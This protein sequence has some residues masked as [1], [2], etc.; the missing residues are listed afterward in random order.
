MKHIWPEEELIEH[1]TLSLDERSLI[2]NKS[3]SLQIGFAILLKFFQYEGRFPV[4][5]N[6]IPKPIIRYIARQI[7]VSEEAFL[8]YKWEGRSIR[9]RRSQIRVLLGFRKWSHRYADELIQWLITNSLTEQFKYEQLKEAA[10]KHLRDLKIE[11]PRVITLERLINSAVSRWEEIFFKNLSGQLSSKSKREMDLLLSDNTLEITKQDS[12]HCEDEDGSSFRKLKA[13]PGAISLKTIVAETSKLQSIRQIDLPSGLFK[14]IPSQLLKRYRDRVITEPA[15][16]M[17]R[18]PPHIQYALLAIFVYL[19]GREITDSLVEI[20]IGIVHRIGARA[21][22]KVESEIINEIKKVRG[23]NEILF[24]MASASKEHPND[25]VKDVIFPAVGEKTIEDIIH[26]YKYSGSAYKLKV[27]I[28]MRASYRSYYRSMLPSIVNAL[29]FRSNNQ[30]HQ[31]IID[32]IKVLKKYSESQLRFYPDD[33]NIP[34]DGIIPAT[35]RELVYEVNGKGQQ[36]INRIAYELCVL[37]ALR[38]KLRCKEVWVVG[39]DRYRNPDDDLPSDFEQK[40]VSYY[41][42]LGL[43]TDPDVF[44]SKLQNN[45]AAS[46]K[47]LDENIPGNPDVTILKKNKGWIKVSPLE[48]QPEPQNLLR[49]KAEINK[50]W[51]TVSLLD[52]LKETDLRINFTEHFKSV[53]QRETIDRAILQKRLLLTLYAMGTN[54]GIKRVIAGDHKEKYS[55]LMYVQRRFVR[56]EYLRQAIASVVNE[57]LRIRLPNIWGEATTSCASDSKQFGA[58]DQNLLTEW[59]I[60]YRGPGV[61]IYWHVEK[62]ASCI[63]SQ[64]KTCSSSEVAA[65]I[66]GVMRHCTEMAVEKQYVDTHGQSYVAFAFCYLLGFKLLPRFKSIHSKKLYRPYAGQSDKY[67]NLQL[68]L[69]RPINWSLISKQYDQMIKFATAIRLGTAET[70]S[71]LRRFTRENLKH[72]TYQA[73][74]ELGKAVRTIFLCDYLR[75]K[76]LRRDIHEGLNVIELWNDVNDFIL[77]GKGGEFATNRKESQ[78]LTM[79]SLHLL[80]NCLVY[81]NTLMIQET[82]Q[83]PALMKSM[84]SDDL[85]GLTPLIFNHIN[86]YGIF[87]LDMN[88]R[89]PLEVKEVA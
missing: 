42:Q 32:A 46:L 87:Q 28:R 6:E 27:N 83:E 33:E 43:P 35:W 36:K 73:L 66:E 52:I 62:G 9:E 82:L 65:M 21:E 75:M 3:A 15:R 79:L 68:V 13:E 17:R 89:I 12:N 26:E 41:E 14:G 67:V 61:M 18:H 88:S 78:E 69:T 85:R 71:I 72:P 76:E 23:K 10:L 57:I 54:A 48:A 50:R 39:A 45:M 74:M 8:D 25:A 1:F 56:K 2:T 63:Y 40:R 64:L 4:A 19:R 49:L 44:I 29:D 86:P 55:D 47:A 16:E 22:R 5:K 58:W 84:T 38:E 81:I 31:P 34:T 51:Q 60:R 11:P 80:Q 30:A 20:F 7:D 70:E 77:F 53:A 59:H 24:K 37:G